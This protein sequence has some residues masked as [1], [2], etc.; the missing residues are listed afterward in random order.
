MAV[1]KCSKDFKKGKVFLT[2]NDDVMIGPFHYLVTKVSLSLRNDVDEDDS[3]FVFLD[4]ENKAEFCSNY[5]GYKSTWDYGFPHFRIDDY[6]AATRL[7][8]ALMKIYENNL[9]WDN[10]YRRINIFKK[11]K[12]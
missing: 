4:I 8:I 9:F 2:F 11:K 3:I 6:E 7:V 5:Y 10:V 12:K 1:Y